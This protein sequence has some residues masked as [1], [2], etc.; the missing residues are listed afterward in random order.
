MCGVKSSHIMLDN[1]I[2]SLRRDPLDFLVWKVTLDSRERRQDIITML[3]SNGFIVYFSYLLTLLIWSVRSEQTSGPIASC[4]M[5]EAIPPNPTQ[6]HPPPSPSLFPWRAQERLC[7]VR[8]FHFD[9]V[10]PMNMYK[11]SNIIF[12]MVIG[13]LPAWSQKQMVITLPSSRCWERPPLLNMTTAI[14]AL[15][16]NGQAWESTEVSWTVIEHKPQKRKRVFFFPFV[17]NHLIFLPQ[18]MN[19]DKIKLKQTLWCCFCFYRNT[20]STCTSPSCFCF[21]L[22]LL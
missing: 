14:N 9:S 7:S 13:L 1:L 21:H 19:D 17:S 18:M 10:R 6:P 4:R 12:L 5:Q 20:D 2:L 11:P 15:I 16:T 8:S 3:I 22:S